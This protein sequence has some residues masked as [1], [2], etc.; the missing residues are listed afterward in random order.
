MYF[1]AL[2]NPGSFS[3][4]DFLSMFYYE[5]NSS[6]K[7]VE[8]IY[9]NSDRNYKEFRKHMDKMPWVALPYEDYRTKKL[10]YVFNVT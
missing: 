4:T 8:V 5:I 10:K 7:L 1:G 3:F 2:Y 6:E 9:V